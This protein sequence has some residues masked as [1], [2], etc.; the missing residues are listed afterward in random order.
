MH[1]AMPVKSRL[2]RSQSFGP[3]NSLEQRAKGLESED[4]LLALRPMLF[5]FRCVTG[6]HGRIRTCT[7]DALDVVSLLLDYMSVNNNC[8]PGGT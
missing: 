1:P 3:W 8:D 7:R 4:L 6:A 2:L 5:A